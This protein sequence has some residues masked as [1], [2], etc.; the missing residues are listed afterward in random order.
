MAGISLAKSKPGSLNIIL[1]AEIEAS[2][3]IMNVVFQY[4]TEQSFLPLVSSSK[5]LLSTGQASG[6]RQPAYHLLKVF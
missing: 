6:P 4:G 3:L 1:I 5:R 2:S